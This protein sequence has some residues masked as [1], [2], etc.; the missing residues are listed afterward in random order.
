MFEFDSEKKVREVLSTFGISIATM[1]SHLKLLTQMG[2]NE[3]LAFPPL[4]V[5]QHSLLSQGFRL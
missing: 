5:P 2:A 4:D 3:R 1:N